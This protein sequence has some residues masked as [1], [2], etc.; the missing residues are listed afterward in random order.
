MKDQNIYQLGE[1]VS[2]CFMWKLMFNILPHKDNLGILTNIVQTRNLAGIANSRFS[3]KYRLLIWIQEEYLLIRFVYSL[4]LKILPNWSLLS[5]LYQ[6]TKHKIRWRSLLQ[7]QMKYEASRKLL[8]LAVWRRF[9]TRLTKRLK[10]Y[11]PEECDQKLSNER[12]TMCSCLHLIRT[13]D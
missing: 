4:R 8:T 13:Y 11:I 7:A 1:V 9:P 2:S 12:V 5:V 3:R 6:E 10:T